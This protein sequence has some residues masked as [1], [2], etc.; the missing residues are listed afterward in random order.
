MLIT[1]QKRPGKQHYN[2]T[3]SALSAA[4]ARLFYIIIITSFLKSYLLNPNMGMGATG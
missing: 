3:M 1:E 4:I 2:I